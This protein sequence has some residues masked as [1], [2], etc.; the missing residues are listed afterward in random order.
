MHVSQ[1]GKKTVLVQHLDI[2]CFVFV[3]DI[4]Q[5]YFNETVNHAGVH[6]IN[7]IVVLESIN[8]YHSKIQVVFGYV[9]GKIPNH[10]LQLIL[11]SREEVLNLQEILNEM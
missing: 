9:L 5:V 10:W 3:K 6:F 2:V 1:E 4:T 8:N 7:E 11:E